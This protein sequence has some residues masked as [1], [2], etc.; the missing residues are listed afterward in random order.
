MKGKEPWKE[1]KSTLRHNPYIVVGMCSCE[2]EEICRILDAH[3]IEYDKVNMSYKQPVW[4]KL[5]EEQQAKVNEAFAG[6]RPVIGFCINETA[7]A[8]ALSLPIDWYGID[9]KHENMAPIEQLDMALD[10]EVTGYHKLVAANSWGF[11][12][13]MRKVA[14]L[15]MHGIGVE[16]RYNR[17]IKDSRIKPENYENFLRRDYDAEEYGME[18]IPPKYRPGMK[19]VMRTIRHRDRRAQGVTADQEKDAEKALLNAELIGSVTLVRSETA[20]SSTLLDRLIECEHFGILMLLGGGLTYFYGPMYKVNSLAEHFPDG[21]VGSGIEDQGFWYGHY[22]Q[23]LIVEY[24]R[25]IE[26]VK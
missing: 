24:M 1:L 25:K 10:G 3:D 20:A 17:I 9:K 6:E 7:P 18:N 13:E 12:F 21:R 16:A 14:A 19:F 2:S 26:N 8:G 15:L 22:S 5:T 4:Q 23:P 11:V